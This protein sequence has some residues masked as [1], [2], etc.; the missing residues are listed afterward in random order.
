MSQLFSHLA[1]WSLQGDVGVTLNGLCYIAIVKR[2][3]AACIV[4]DVGP[5]SGK[6]V[7]F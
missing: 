3:I 6:L 5:R 4:E 7:V 1:I 2:H